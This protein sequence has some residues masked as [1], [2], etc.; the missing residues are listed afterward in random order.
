MTETTTPAKDEASRLSVVLTPHRSLSP[1][2]FLVVMGLLGSVSFIAGVVFLIVGAW[3]V[4]GFL[5]L[6]VLLVYWAF[7][8]NYRSALIRET[9]DVTDETVIVRRF[10]QAGRMREWT[11]Q[12]Y[13]L[14]IEM[15]EDED[16]CG[17]L[18][19]SSHGR[20]LAVGTFLS[21]DERK[22][23][24]AELRSVLGSASSH[25]NRVVG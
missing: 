15:T 14:K 17:P 20:R 4:I 10:D 11:F 9:V 25:K 23:F 7:Q 21:A 6:D 3:P 2:G 1:T 13:W 22:D 24:A 19:L 16:T 8:A 18:F 12:P 5:G